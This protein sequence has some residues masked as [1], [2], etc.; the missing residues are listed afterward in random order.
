MLLKHAWSRFNIILFHCDNQ[1]KKYAYSGGCAT[2]EEHRAKGANLDVD[3][4]FTYL[5]FFL[6]DQD[7]LDTIRKEYGS[8]QMLSGSVD[9]HCSCTFSLRGCL[10]KSVRFSMII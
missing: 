2:I 7:R 10:K 8:G 3:V 9:G 6:E 5:S 4:P 1:I